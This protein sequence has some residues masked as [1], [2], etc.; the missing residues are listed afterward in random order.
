VL[1]SELSNESGG[2]IIEKDGIGARIDWRQIGVRRDGAVDGRVYGESEEP[3]GAIAEVG[4]H[5]SSISVAFEV[6]FCKGRV[7]WDADHGCDCGMRE[8]LE[9]VA[10]RQ[11]GE[12]N[13]Y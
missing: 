3:V 5:R 9:D 13:K 12:W 1:Q 4:V 7:G 2:G 10:G 11:H 6:D 8:A